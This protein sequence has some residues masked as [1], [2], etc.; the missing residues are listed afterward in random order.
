MP[1]DYLASLTAPQRTS[2]TNLHL[3]VSL[4]IVAGALNAGGFLA[5][6]QYT[7]HMTGIV[8]SAADNIVLGHWPSVISGALSF[9]AFILGAAT[10]SL[11]VNYGKRHS[12]P[13]PFTKPLLLESALLLGFGVLGGL[14]VVQELASI[15]VIAMLLCYVMGLQ[16]ALITK[17]SNAEIRTTHVTGLVTDFG[18]ELGRML[19][20]NRS[21]IDSPVPM[22]RAN[23]QKLTV[24]LWL[25]GAFFG[26][27][28]VGAYGFK[29]IGYS[30]TI[31][32]AL[33]LVVISVAPSFRPKAG[34]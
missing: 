13:N 16:N 7:S 5:I 19:Y 9:V 27:G 15:T 30:L 1:V 24:H 32:L 10:T 28:L 29:N 2:R 33:G 21:G 11:L 12:V 4:A 34:G 25:I 8:S 22:I 3:G 23:R 26:G 20:W 18:I 6:G 14:L 17:V 31:P